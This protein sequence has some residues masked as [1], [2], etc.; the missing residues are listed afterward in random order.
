M[1]ENAHKRFGTKENIP[2]KNK[3]FFSQVGR[4]Y[5]EDIWDMDA[6]KTIG[7]FKNDVC[8]VHGDIDNDVPISCSQKALKVYEHASLTVIKGA[9]HGF[10]GKATEEALRTAYAFIRAHI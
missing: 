8:L 9:G 5:Y 6:Y 2:E 10:G 7:R 3:I 1:P 4:R